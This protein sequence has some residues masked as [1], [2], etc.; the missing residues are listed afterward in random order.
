MA[1]GNRTG[2]GHPPIKQIDYEELD[3]LIGIGCTGEE[4]AHF[5]NV[6]YD[7]LNARVKEKYGQS[8]SEYH[9]YKASKF[10][11]SLRRMQVRSAM[12]EKDEKGKYV[13]YPNVNMQVWLGK[14]FL[15]Q[16]DKQEM[17]HEGSAFSIILTEQPDTEQDSNDK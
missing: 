14:Q 12:G 3:K 17:K 1:K 15:N 9:D 13:L 6:D 11:V 2:K 7:T 16:A 4:C 5:F 10:K 8:F